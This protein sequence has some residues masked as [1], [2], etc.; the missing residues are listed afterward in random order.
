MLERGEKRARKQI[1]KDLYDNYRNLAY[2]GAKVQRGLWLANYT[3]K[4]G[5]IKRRAIVW[6]SKKLRRFVQIMGVTSLIESDGSTTVA[7]QTIRIRSNGSV[8]ADS[9]FRK[10]EFCSSPLHKPQ[11]TESY[12]HLPDK[13]ALDWSQK[14]LMD[15]STQALS[16]DEDIEE[17]VRKGVYPLK[18]ALKAPYDRFKRKNLDRNS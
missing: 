7:D 4:D 3:G 15:I 6:H 8:R 18:Y 13:E 5:V 12:I 11:R 16:P 17:S 1:G 9:Y 10:A 14:T 2:D